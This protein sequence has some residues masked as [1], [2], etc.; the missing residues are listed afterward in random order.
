MCGIHAYRLA[1]GCPPAAHPI[2]PVA[3]KGLDML[4]GH[5]PELMIVLVLALIVFGP[6]KLPEIGGALGKT[7]RGFKSEVSNLTEEHALPEREPLTVVEP[8]VT[9]RAG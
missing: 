7:I 5:L 6:Q 2:Q 3:Q 8:E 4:G 1:M 9:H